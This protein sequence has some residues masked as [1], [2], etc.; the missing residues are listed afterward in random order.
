MPLMP[1]TVKE[2]SPGSYEAQFYNPKTD[3]THPMRARRSG[4]DMNVGIYP[5]D[6]SPSKNML[7]DESSAFVSF[8]EKQGDPDKLRPFGAYVEEPNRRQGMGTAMYDMASMITPQ[9]IVQSDQQSTGAEG[10]WA[11]QDPSGWVPTVQTGEP[12]DIA[13]RLLKMPTFFQEES[14]WLEQQLYQAGVA[15][16]PPDPATKPPPRDMRSDMGEVRIVGRGD[17]PT[18]RP[19]VFAE[20][21]KRTHPDDWPEAN[22]FGGYR[23]ADNRPH[24]TVH[25]EKQFQSKDDKVRATFWKPDAHGV[26]HVPKF[27]VRDDSRGK[28][29][30]RAGWEELLAEIKALYGD[31]VTVKPTDILRESQ[32]FWDRIGAEG[33]P[34]R[35]RRET[36]PKGRRTSIDRTQKI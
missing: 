5:P 15:P 9:S 2:V 35:R 12:M 8:K 30:G 27:A 28:G 17:L 16:N 21:P 33:S 1:E 3:V 36:Y 20:P 7:D 10:M 26:V 31:H 32:G 18:R 23:Y 19:E 25:G 22:W 6:S 34:Y 11:N 29:H 4:N 13:W 24:L 14:P